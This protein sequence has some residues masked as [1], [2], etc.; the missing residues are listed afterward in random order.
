MQETLGVLRKKWAAEGDK[1]P[2]IVHGMRMRIGVNTGLITTGNM[3]SNIRKNYTMMGDAVNLAARL[4]SAA[5]QYGVYTMISHNTCELVRNDF[6]VRQVDKI[7]VVGKSEPVVVYELLARKADDDGRFGPLLD[8]YQEGLN[9]FY[10]REWDAAIGKLEAANE[11][12]P[13][14][15]VAPN[16][17]TPSKKIIE[18]CEMYRSHPPDADWDGVMRLSSK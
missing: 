2:E 12:E 9:Y 16:G 15:A 8:L 5:K 10:A 6:L 18:Y 3:G 13:F 11:K 1:W 7:T 17:M 4:E 14:K